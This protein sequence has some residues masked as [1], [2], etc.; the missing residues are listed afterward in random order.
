MPS[1]VLAVID[2]AVS[3]ATAAQSLSRPKLRATR[4]PAPIELEID[5]AVLRIGRGA[6]MQTIAAVPEQCT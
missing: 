4:L 2:P 1:F 5:G 6:D 3:E